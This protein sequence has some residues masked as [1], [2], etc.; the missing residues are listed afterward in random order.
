MAA[1]STA[2]YAA[3]DRAL[4]S[5]SFTPE[6]LNPLTDLGDAMRYVKLSPTGPCATALAEGL[7]CPVDIPLPVVAAVPEE[8]WVKTCK[9]LKFKR[10]EQDAT[11]TPIEMGQMA[12]IRRVARAK[13]GI[14]DHIPTPTSQALV[15]TESSN[16]AAIRK[17]K[18]NTICS[19][20][21]DTEITVETKD[22]A[23]YQARWQAIFGS[24]TKPREEEEVTQIQMQAI[25]HLVKCLV[26]PYLDLAVW[27]PY[28][29]RTQEKLTRSKRLYNPDGT[30]QTVE[31]P[32]PPDYEAWAA[33]FDV[34][35]TAYLQA[36]IVDAG[37]LFQYKEKIRK[38]DSEYGQGLWWLIYQADCHA[39]QEHVERKDT[40]NTVNN[41]GVPVARR[42]N[43]A[44][45]DMLA[46]D[47]WWAKEVDRLA[48]HQL[49]HE[50]KARDAASIDATTAQSR[51]HHVATSASTDL[52]RTSF[53]PPAPSTSYN[54]VQQNTTKQ[55]GQARVVNGKYVMTNAGK[56]P[57]PKFQLNRCGRTIGGN[58][59]PD[60]PHLAHQCELC[61]QQGH[62]SAGPACPKHNQGADWTRRTGGKSGKNKGGKGCKSG[63]NRQRN[64]WSQ[65]SS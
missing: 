37:I 53:T 31:L 11:P 45:G 30:H 46:D 48:T 5:S 42:W 26:N 55:K 22:P 9:E 62:G 54:R 15:T 47:S 35:I 44:W 59:C 16:A 52:H 65:W 38:H 18:M 33:C 23:I 41:G 40:D 28:Q 60:G 12:L 8:M 34:L 25:E 21:D 1:S 61:L 57:C 64:N 56:T 4:G 43:E 51:E 19:Q 7:G 2:D 49:L 29:H 10:G 14:Q 58:G 17:I 27:G 3:M 63:K 13:L 32:G 36:D 20:I 50:R 39:R 24:K 6:I